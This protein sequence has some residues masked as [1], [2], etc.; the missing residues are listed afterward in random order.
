MIFS[1]RGVILVSRKNINYKVQQDAKR[2]PHYGIRKLSIGVASVLLGT[3][4][5]MQNGTVHA[6]VNST[7]STGNDSVNVINKDSGTSDSAGVASTSAGASSTNFG[8][9]S[10]NSASS[11]VSTGDAANSAAPSQVSGSPIEGATKQESNADLAASEPESATPASQVNVGTDNSNAIS[12]L[13]PASHHRATVGNQ[14][15]ERLS[16]NL[17]LSVNQ[18]LNF[19]PSSLLA[20]KVALT[21][22]NNAVNGGFD[23]ATWGKLDVNA[24]KGSVQG[25]YYQLT[26]YTGDANH[27]IVPNEA[28]FEK[29]GISTAGKQVGVTSDL[30]HTI[31]RDK[32]TAQDVTVAFSKTDNKMVKAIN[33]NWS[34]TWGHPYYLRAKLSKF[35]GTNLDVS[36]VT[37]MSYMFY[38]DQISD[39][40]PLSNWKVD[41]VTNMSRMFD[42]NSS[43][44]T[45]NFQAKRVVNFIYPEGYTGKKQSP[46]TQ[47]IDVPQ[48]VNV[49]LITKDSKPSNNILDWVTKT[50]TPETPASVYFQAYT[51][52]EIKG[53]LEPDKTVIA[54]QQADITKPINVTVTYKL[55]ESNTNDAFALDSKNGLHE[56]ANVNDNGGYDTDFWGTLDV[57]KFTTVRN[58]DNLEITGYTGDASKVIIPN[59]AD[60]EIDNL[61]QGAKQVTISSDVMH[62]L[63]K[64]A[65]RIGLSKTN[66][67]K[68]VASD[69]IWQDAFGGM[70]NN[71]RTGDNGDGGMWVYNPNL[72]TMD[73]HNLDTTNI[74]DMSAMF[75]G[76]R[77]LK[78]VG[79]LSQWNV[80]NVASMKIMFQRAS[81]LTNIGDLD[82]WDTSEVTDMNS[83]FIYA[84]N[85]T[86]I[87]DLSKWQT[88][89]VTNMGAMFGGTTNLTNIGNLDNW[90]TGN[91]TDMSY[92][93][94]NATSLTNIG[95]L[96]NW[97]TSNVTDMSYM[98]A[99]AA[100]LTNIG[101]LSKWQTG[102]VTD[103]HSMFYNAI[104][105]TNIGDLSKWQ[106]G[107][108]TNMN[109]M[110]SNATGLTNI[111]NLDDWNTS[112][113]TDMSWMFGTGTDTGKQSHLTNIGDL[114]KWQTGNVTDMSCMFSNAT[115][116][117]NIG[118]LS[119][120]DTSE[121][122]DMHWMFGTG[123]GRQSHLTNIGDLSKWN[124]SKVTDMHW[125]F[126]NATSLINIGDLSKWQTDNVT[127]MNSMFLNATS[128]I[129]IGNLD[130]WDTGNVTNMSWM[131]GTGTDI[132]KQSHLTNI[133]DL[134]KWQ[135]GNVTNMNSMFSNATNLTNIGDLSNWDT[136][137]VTDM[138][139]M[140][141][142]TTNLINIGNLDNWDTSKVTDMS[143]M[144]YNAINLTNIGDLSKWQ[145]GNVTNM[146]YMFT[147]ATH[148]TNVGDLSKWDTS[149]VT[150]MM[151]MFVS[152]NALRYLNISNW[153]LTKLANKDSMKYMFADDTDLTIIA[154]DLA[155]PAWYQN[156]IN[157]A[158][159]FW[160][161]HIAVITNVPE[162][163]KSTGDINNLKIDD[164]DASRSI[165]Y[166]S[167]GSSDAVAV[168]KQANQ[169]Y[170]KQ[171]QNEHPG[172]TLNLAADV[173]QTDPI[174][175]ANAKFVSAPREVQFT[176]AY[177]DLTGKLVDSTTST[178][179]VGETVAISPVAPVNYVLA[180]GRLS[181]DYLMRLGLNEVDFLV[182][183][184]FTTTAETKTVSRTIKVQT[185][186]GQ[187]NNVVQMITFV[188]NGYLNQV[189]K[190]TTYSSWSFGGQYQFSGYLPKQMDGYT[191]DVIP[192]VIVTP[193]SLNTTVNVVYHK[194][195]VVY[196]IDYKLANGTV[197]ENVSAT[198]ERDGTIHLTAPQGYRLM[199]TVP[200]VQVG[201]SSRKLSV[202]V[203]PNEQTYTAYSALPSVV[204]DPL[205]KTITRTINITMPNGRVRRV[206]QQVHFVR[207]ATV[208][209]N[210]KITYSNWTGVGQMSFDRLFVPKRR[211]YRLV[212]T[213][214]QGQTLTGV[215]QMVV[216][217][218]MDNIVINVKYV[219]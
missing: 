103:M 134:S 138:H 40:S 110:F 24:W 37:D 206:V 61:D 161:H 205:T 81:S 30:M 172:Y 97:N 165:F 151:W 84:T 146:A 168:L 201:H 120:W 126:A 108:V 65:T 38:E 13:P 203:L 105:L 67:Q 114:S 72:T 124:T 35:D 98:F 25:D 171:Y 153:D 116:L 77:N 178:H 3:V 49:E 64:N 32:T 158:D 182:E 162:L 42:N 144:F 115:D 36:N 129:N 131:F 163:I 47:T 200:D 186:D 6:D 193:D 125:M 93:F 99:N 187:T 145:T 173:D 211:G 9:G 68:V 91:V 10:A 192:A 44:Q 218:T 143:G 80:A 56:H 83:M 63:A 139:W 154:N 190:R 52:P 18:K 169:A 121:V 136:S 185:P 21:G 50:E 69:A 88:D 20:S 90:N 179:K 210:G 140:F 189:T 102:N 159:Y 175:L 71:P 53:L 198:P 164:Q 199:T 174:A 197:V 8:V 133:G 184:K 43:T 75:N 1:R 157:D 167:R 100:N 128:L 55:V 156:E 79:D 195:P 150:N 86:N 66:N 57:S 104:N 23:E 213:D 107:N 92:M 176:I 89:N 219:K 60:F 74:T 5:Y 112:N 12:S 58:G 39:L 117:T 4:F 135:T 194:V 214:K 215:S 132:G 78:V 123:T 122:T 59:I 41:N 149:N 87:G 31:F 207:T 141:G 119:N 208:A 155:L 45:K 27:V 130:N 111:G 54:G 29:A 70:T 216:D 96:Y 16:A 196:E 15:N 22:S 11:V 28:D 113:V 166:D 170:I 204:T 95:N 26:D 180:N 14:S 76:G 160:N 191:A 48:E 148:L 137:K 62:K 142:G 73:L 183:P 188:R 181:T 109:S 217:P 19:N 101:D 33:T 202:L 2:V 7:V 51:V 177:Y 106:T 209:A 147:N 118:D 46:V 127:D 152:T 82:N 17:S 34:N 212:M 85:L 94:A